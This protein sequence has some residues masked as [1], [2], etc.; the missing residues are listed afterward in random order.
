MYG[1]LFGDL[2]AAKNETKKE[3]K[4]GEIVVQPTASKSTPGVDAQGERKPAAPSSILPRFI[5]TQAMRPR[6]QQNP[7]KRLMPTDASRVQPVLTEAIIHVH[8]EEK[9][10]DPIAA[11]R[12][13]N[14][15]AVE[16]L[17]LTFNTIVGYSREEELP[18]RHDAEV[19]VASTESR[20][21]E[22]AYL[23]LLHERAKEDPYDPLVPNDLLQYWERKALAVEREKLMEQ[24]E[25]TIREQ[26]LL[27]LQLEQE[28]MGLEKL[29]D[30]DKIVEHRVQRSLGM[31]RGGVSNLPAWLVEKHKLR[32]PSPPP[33]P[34]SS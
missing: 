17:S 28:R 4:D 34:P 32:Q 14:S 5:P 29:G 25:E 21:Q 2:P 22:P 16:G 12:L 15:S 9:Y 1:G 18:K 24:R 6:Q 27:R 13:E 10:V 31:G 33:P 19:V 23:H 20:K 11:T 7:R 26:E 30:V 8:G 3:G